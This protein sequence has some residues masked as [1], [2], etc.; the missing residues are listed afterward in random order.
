VLRYLWQLLSSESFKLLKFFIRTFGCQ[1]NKHDSERIA[2]VLINEGYSPVLKP[3]EADVIIFNTC[4]VRQHA[5]D[6]LFGNVNALKSLKNKKQNLIIAVGGCLAQKRKGEIFK[7]LPHVN[8]VF[9][10]YNIS[11]LPTLINSAK[12]NSHKVCEILERSAILP[13]KLPIERESKLFAWVPVSIGCNNFCSY[14]VVPYVR[15]REVSLSLDEIKQE[16]EEFVSQGAKEVTLLGQNVNS[17]G[18]DIYGESQFDILLRELDKIEELERI[19]FTTSHPKDLNAKIIDAVSSCSSVCEHFHLPVQAGSSKI[20]KLMNRGYL[21][22]DYLAIIEKIKAKIPEYSITTDIMVGFP[23]ET[24]EDFEETLDV[25]K[26]VRFDQAFMFIYSP[27]DVTPAL[28]MPGQIP[29]EI[30]S[31]RF[32]RLVELQNQITWE[33]NRK[34]VGKRL[35]VLV[36]GKSKKDNQMFSG[37]TRTNKIVNFAALEEMIGSFVSVKIIKALKKS[38]IGEL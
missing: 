23:G 30:K 11:N 18:R 25:V 1:M 24:E 36:E 35:E 26:K 7:F 22:E 17:Y 6:R 15:G 29:E 9:G 20:L 4:C 33:E 14:C 28:K 13:N 27:R 16:V 37:R 8:L 10:T 31:E 19:R 21:K 32:L 34:L 5:E 2:G 38:L 12:K 3:E